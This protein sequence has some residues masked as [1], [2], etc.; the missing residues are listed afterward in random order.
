MRRGEKERMYWEL[1][2]VIYI[3]KLST[4]HFLPMIGFPW[5]S[6]VE[7]HNSMSNNLSIRSPECLI[8]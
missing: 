3:R 4:S 7:R 2:M 8:L 1:S 6:Q 5:G